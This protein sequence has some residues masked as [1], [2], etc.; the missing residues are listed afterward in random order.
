MYLWQRSG[1]QKW[2]NGNKKRLRAAAGDQLTIIEEAGRKRLLLEVASPSRAKLQSL[3]REFDGRILKLPHDWLKR[4]SREQK[5]KSIR[6]GKRLLIV[7]VGG[8]SVS[9]P[10][11]Q[12]R[13]TESR[14][15]GPSHLFI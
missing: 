2:W 10:R 15:I 8:T 3:A 14:P 6:V 11:P 13:Q 12:A 5:N 9:R 4:F 7:N 1:S